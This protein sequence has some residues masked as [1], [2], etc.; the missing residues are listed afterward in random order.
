MKHEKKI[1]ILKP[2]LMTLIQWFVEAF[3]IVVESTKKLYVNDRSV[4]RTRSLESI[5][6][7]SS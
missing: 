4:V 1:S 5:E 2:T 6:K 3:L 7:R